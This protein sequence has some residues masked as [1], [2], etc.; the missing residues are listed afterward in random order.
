[1]DKKASLQEILLCASS[2]TI[3]FGK[4]AYVKQKV[5]RCGVEIAELRAGQNHHSKQPNLNK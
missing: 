3:L 5:R 1:M 2:A 4:L